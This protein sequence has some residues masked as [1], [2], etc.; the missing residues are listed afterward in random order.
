[1]KKECKCCEEEK[2]HEWKVRE[3]LQCLP[4]EEEVMD[5]AELFKVFGDTTRCKI[6]SCLFVSP[7]CVCDIAKILNMTKSAVS[8]QLRIL[9]NSGLVKY[10]KVG[11]EVIYSLDDEHIKTMFAMA[12]EHLEE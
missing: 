10:K 2:I 6:I 3:V 12:K 4:D 7:I 11:K 9:R 1:M 5:I 8:H